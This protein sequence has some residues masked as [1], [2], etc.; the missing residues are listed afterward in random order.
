MILQVSNPVSHGSSPFLGRGLNISDHDPGHGDDVKLKGERGTSHTMTFLQRA[1]CVFF[2][3]S[4]AGKWTKTYLDSWGTA[5]AYCS[6]SGRIW[7][8]YLATWKALCVLP[9][10]AIDSTSEKKSP[11]PSIHLTKRCPKQYVRTQKV[12]PASNTAG[13][14]Y[15]FVKKNRNINCWKRRNVGNDVWAPIVYFWIDCGKH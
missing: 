1:L 6:S 15:T 9:A 5:E 4:F 12:F 13:F 14:E 8:Q 7:P 2:C 10:Y 11:T 3:K